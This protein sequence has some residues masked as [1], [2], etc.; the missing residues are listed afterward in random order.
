MESTGPGIPQHPDAR[1]RQRWQPPASTAPA[2]PSRHLPSPTFKIWDAIVVFLVGELV[3]A[4]VGFSIG[5]GLSGDEIGEPGALTLGLGFAG[6]F[7]T[8][9]IVTWLFCRHRGTGSLRTDLGLVVHWSDWWVV[10][11]GVVCAIGLGLLVLPLRQLIDDTQSVVDD[12]NDSSGAKLAV[13]A[14]AAGL[15]APIFEE[16]LFRGLLLR[17]L[18]AVV[19]VPW[20]IGISAVAF[21]AV[22]FIGGSVLGTLAVFPALVA[23]GA[24]AAFFAVRTGDLSRSILLHVGF[25]LLAVIGAIL[26]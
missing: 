20:A 7:V 3:G 6:Q 15:L 23:L 2:V 12:L 1:A 10:P 14:V 9:G 25:N 5:Y 21:G 17:A 26:S 11:F 13:I 18:L 16:L 4:T 8:I 22:H 24:I 19:S